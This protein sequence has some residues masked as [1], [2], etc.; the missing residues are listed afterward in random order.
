M[1]QKESVDVQCV[2][3]NI[4]YDV[5]DNSI[6][7]IYSSHF[8]EHIESL[9]ELMKQVNRILKPGGKMISIVPHFSNPYYHSDYTHKRPW[10]LYTLLYF[11]SDIFFKRNVP[12][13][14]NLVDFKLLDIKLKFAS[15]FRIT[16]RLKI[17]WEKL[18]NLNRRTMEIYEEHFCWIIPC[19][20]IRFVIEKKIS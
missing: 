5:P 13:Y 18:F 20:E 11:S 12:R 14:Y 3:P 1:V 9:E 10:G 8:L 2:L 17:V 4:L 19:Y 7:L 16:N 6:D 15:P